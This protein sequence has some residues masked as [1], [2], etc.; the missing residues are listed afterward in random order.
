MSASAVAAATPNLII[1][2]NPLWFAAPFGAE[3]FRLLR[4]ISTSLS[5]LTALPAANQAERRVW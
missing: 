4:L 1:V 3:A 2:F 5:D